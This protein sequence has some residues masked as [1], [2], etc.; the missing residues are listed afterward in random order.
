[1]ATVIYVETLVNVHLY[2][3][4]ETDADSNHNIHALVYSLQYELMW[5]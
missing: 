4:S 2:T 3:R 5:R 1:M